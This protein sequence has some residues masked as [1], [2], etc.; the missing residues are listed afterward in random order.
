VA[1]AG[2]LTLTMAAGPMTS[3]A[4]SALGPVM[5]V[6]LELGRAQLGLLT[7]MLFIVAAAASGA[8]GRATDAF[9]GDRLLVVALGLSSFALGI[10]AGAHSYVWLVAAA[11][12]SGLSVAISNPATNHIILLHIEPASQSSV[13]GVKQAGVLASGM[14]AGTALPWGASSVGWRWPVLAC[15]LLTVCGMA[16]SRRLLRQA[17]PTEL[18]KPA[19]T[20]Q[21]PRVPVPGIFW[22]RWYSFF[23]GAGHLGAIVYLPLYAFDTGRLSPATAGLLIAAVGLSG[24]CA[25][26]GLGAAGGRRLWKLP[27]V[28]ALLAFFSGLSKLVIWAS[29]G[30]GLGA[31]WIGAAVFGATSG[32]WSGLGQ[33]ATIRIGGAALAGRASGAVTRSY[34]IG[35]LVS[36]ALFGQLVER[37]GTYGY[38]WALMTTCS[39]M[40]VAGAQRLPDASGSRFSATGP[41]TQQT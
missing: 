18:R 41:D 37:T 13:T 5:V 38:G 23:M 34:Y 15:A 33:L 35:F 32:G 31:L 6:E 39:L 21:G 7:T 2:L 10:L 27:T 24:V 20:R 17:G 40:A 29:P 9:G 25:R 28:L 3:F 30:V 22:L 12:C 19:Q 14:V 4:F 16:L 36:P 1:L 8:A 11:F 26:V